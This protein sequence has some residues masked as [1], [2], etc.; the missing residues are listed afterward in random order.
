M[1]S[2]KKT[3]NTENI[4]K[5]ADFVVCFKVAKY[6]ETPEYKDFMKNLMTMRGNMDAK[7][8]YSAVVSKNIVMV[9]RDGR[10]ISVK[11]ACDEI[12]YICKVADDGTAEMREFVIQD[13]AE[14]K[15]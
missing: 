13:Y 11:E 1:P 7:V 9:P 6:Y 15:F 2:A 8:Q 12:D 10:L 3:M 14:N 5:D 4:N